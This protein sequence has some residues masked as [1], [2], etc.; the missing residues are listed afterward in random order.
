[1]YVNILNRNNILDQKSASLKNLVT[2]R[3]EGVSLGSEFLQAVT[4]A[5]LF[6]HVCIQI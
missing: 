5:H 2:L 1:M 3:G 6:Q 4:Y